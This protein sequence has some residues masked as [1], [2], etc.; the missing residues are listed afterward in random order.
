MNRRVRCFREKALGRLPV[1][2][3]V[4][5]EVDHSLGVDFAHGALC[6]V[7]REAMGRLQLDGAWAE[8]PLRPSL[9]A[10]ASCRQLRQ[11][12]IGQP[13]GN[14]GV[15]RPLWF[16]AQVACLRKGCRA[17][18]LGWPVKTHR[19]SG[20]TALSRVGALR[21]V[22]AYVRDGVHACTACMV[23]G[24]AMSTAAWTCTIAVA[25]CSAVMAGAA[26]VASPAAA[27]ATALIASPV[28][29]GVSSIAGF[30]DSERTLKKGQAC[31]TEIEMEG[32]RTTHGNH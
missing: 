21:A 28:F 4:C 2:V 31:V 8:A 1:C 26:P 18:T 32:H 15:L 6:L 3:V 11:I 24:R 25:V 5:V 27:S 23:P 16:D 9:D 10:E 19:A 12:G 30:C 20:R 14:K 17:L 22:V 29:S 7:Q 13:R